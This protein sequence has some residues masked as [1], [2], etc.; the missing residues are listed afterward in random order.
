ME[1]GIHGGNP[2][3]DGVEEGLRL[4]SGQAWSDGQ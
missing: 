4:G 1:R 3:R 2:G